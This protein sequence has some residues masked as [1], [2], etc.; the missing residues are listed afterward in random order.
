[1]AAKYVTSL[2]DYHCVKIAKRCLYITSLYFTGGAHAIVGNI[3]GI[4]ALAG[5]Q[6]GVVEI[7]RMKYR[8]PCLQ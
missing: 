5:K 6:W 1:M 3:Y 8:N 2:I 7:K 4:N